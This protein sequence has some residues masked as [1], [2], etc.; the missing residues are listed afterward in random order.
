MP[1]RPPRWPSRLAPPALAAEDILWSVQGE[2]LDEA[3]FCVEVREAAL[4]A[5]HYVLE[6]IEAEP[7]RRLFDHLE[8][9]R[10]GGWLV[11]E[12]LLLP[13]VS[14]PEASAEHVT[15]AA[16]GMLGMDE[17]PRL[18]DA[19]QHAESG[20]QRTGIVRALQLGAGRGSR[21]SLAVSSINALGL[22]TDPA[23]RGAL[24][25]ALLSHEIRPGQWLTRDLS[26][27]TPELAQAAARLARRCADPKVQAQ[28]APLAQAEDPE[29]R[30][31]TLD[32][33]LVLGLP[34][35]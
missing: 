6:E 28:L 8:A 23:T 12:R 30:R 11:C 4:D 3:S 20:E 17:G 29:L 34:G 5:P 7:E 13:T 10:R 16:L 1:S 27:D 2:H 26:S 22:V 24:L 35:A 15:A 25:R 21:E 14:D 31:A 19:L 18:L 32:S 9:L 33:A